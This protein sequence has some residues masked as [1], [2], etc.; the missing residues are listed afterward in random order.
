[1]GARPVAIDGA[2][3]SGGEMGEGKMEGEERGWG[4]APFL[5]EWRGVG[6]E[7]VAGGE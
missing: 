2:V 7:P 5:V 3:L 6:G 4:G 1:V